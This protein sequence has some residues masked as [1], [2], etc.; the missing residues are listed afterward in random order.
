MIEFNAAF[1]KWFGD[2]K[3]VDENGQPLVMYHGTDKEFTAFQPR[4]VVHGWFT[5][6]K[7]RAEEY[8]NNVL[9]VYLR[10]ENPA[11]FSQSNRYSDERL[12]RMGHDGVLGYSE[13]EYIA[14]VFSA[15]Q[16]KSV[17]NDGTWDAD[18]PN[19]T[20]NP[21]IENMRVHMSSFPILALHEITNK[22]T[23]EMKPYGFWYACGDEWIHWVRRE[24][25]D[26]EGKYL[27]DVILKPSA[28]ILF[29][30]TENQKNDFDFD[31]G[32]NVGRYNARMVNWARVAS[33]YDGIEICPSQ[34]RSP[35]WYTAWDVASGCIWNIHAIQEL[36]LIES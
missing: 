28:N 20:S 23:V 12:K 5:S 35:T 3:V 7:Q 26:W 8:G 32:V 17:D 4:G 9:A 15:S 14:Y 13:G 18:D 6:R 30:T 11:S 36:R 2:S 22:Q 27:Y 25:P 24:M 1:R 21:I 10:L 19:I 34:S 29:I 16:I 31:Y 33:K